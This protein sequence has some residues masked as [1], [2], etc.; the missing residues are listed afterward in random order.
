MGPSC[1]LID[2]PRCHPENP[3]LWLV[4]CLVEAELMLRSTIPTFSATGCLFFM[5]QWLL[6]LLFVLQMEQNRW[7]RGQMVHL[8][9]LSGASQYADNKWVFFKWT[10]LSE[11]SSSPAQL[12]CCW[13]HCCRDVYLTGVDVFW[14][15]SL[16]CIKEVKPH[17]VQSAFISAVWHPS[18]NY[19]QLRNT[20]PSHIYSSLLHWDHVTFPHLS[21]LFSALRVGSSFHKSCSCWLR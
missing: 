13:F 12:G 8:N 11:W 21:A 4:I 18:V 9:Y 1:N 17:N 6:L 10:G 2:C 16:V 15:I 5:I 7:K 3:E 19:E 20:E 14:C